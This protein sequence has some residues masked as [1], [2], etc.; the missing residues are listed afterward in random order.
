MKNGHR[1]VTLKWSKSP[2]SQ[3]TLECFVLCHIV[4][5]ESL[6][7]VCLEY[8][9]GCM[10]AWFVLACHIALVGRIIV[11]HVKPVLSLYD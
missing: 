11:C 8:M 10:V 9:E 1:V 3:T 7:S 6:H 4:N 5:S 2:K